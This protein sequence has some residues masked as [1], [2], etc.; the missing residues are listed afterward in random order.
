M[1]FSIN[2]LYFCSV[3]YL[4][5]MSCFRIQILYKVN[6]ISAMHKAGLRKISSGIKN[7][8]TALR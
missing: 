4:S 1:F 5:V 7:K 2:I 3:E 8:S 6:K